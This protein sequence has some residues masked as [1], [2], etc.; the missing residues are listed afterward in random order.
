M[1][2]QDSILR[3][4]IAQ[5][6]TQMGRAALAGLRE[7][8]HAESQEV[9]LVAVQALG[10]IADPDTVSDLVDAL[11][12]EDWAVRWTAVKG[13]ENVGTPEALTIVRRWKSLE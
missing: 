3:E 8:L 7:C 6:L 5:S 4:V 13:L 2:G 11:Q 9:R 1:Y 12:D 10:E